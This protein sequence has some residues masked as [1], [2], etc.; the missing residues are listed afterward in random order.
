MIAGFGR[1]HCP[2]LCPT[3]RCGG[4]LWRA[5][6]RRPGRPGL[7]PPGECAIFP[8][9]FVPFHTA[10]DTTLWP[11]VRTYDSDNEGAG[12]IRRRASHAPCPTA[13]V[14]WVSRHIRSARYHQETGIAVD[15]IYAATEY[16]ESGAASRS[17]KI[18]KPAGQHVDD[19]LPHHVPD[20]NGLHCSGGGCSSAR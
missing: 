8:A 7:V 4:W 20:R 5:P 12:P 13:Q 17:T 19:L 6:G 9:V 1:R 15:V 14:C 11:D 2:V 16:A 10:V 18:R 3:G